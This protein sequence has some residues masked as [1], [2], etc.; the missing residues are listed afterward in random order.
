MNDYC[1][2]N[3]N[4]NHHIMGMQSVTITQK[5]RKFFYPENFFPVSRNLFETRVLVNILR[6]VSFLFMCCMLHFRV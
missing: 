5:P 1:C 2:P 3:S 4:S 6:Q